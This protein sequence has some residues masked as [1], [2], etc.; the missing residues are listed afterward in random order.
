MYDIAKKLSNLAY[1]LENLQL[2]YNTVCNKIHAAEKRAMAEM[3]EANP[4]DIPV[5]VAGVKAYIY[6]LAAEK[7][8]VQDKVEEV[9][10]EM[11]RIIAA[12]KLSEE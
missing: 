11:T 3:L 4:N 12:A 1:D 8:I 2:E 10:T 6:D 7:E 9:K 5:I